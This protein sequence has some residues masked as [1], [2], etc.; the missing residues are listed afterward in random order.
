MPAR[1]PRHEQ[2]AAGIA[3]HDEQQQQSPAVERE[4]RHRDPV[5]RL[6]GL[7]MEAPRHEHHADMVEDEQTERADAQPVQ[8]VMPFHAPAL[9]TRGVLRKL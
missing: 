9:G 8:T 4:H 1:A 2:R 6:R 3:R 5:E 7:H